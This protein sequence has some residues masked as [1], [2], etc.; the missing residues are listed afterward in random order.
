MKKIL[1]TVSALLSLMLCGCTDNEEI[2][3]LSETT[4]AV[5][6]Y[7]AHDTDMTVTGEV[8][9]IVGNEVTVALGTINER[10]GDSQDGKQG[11]RL[12]SGSPETYA[13]GETPQKLSDDKSS[14]IPLYDEMSHKPMD[15]EMPDFG[16]E[17]QGGGRHSASIEKNGK[18]ASYIIPVGMTID[19]LAGRSSDYSGITEGMVITLTIDESGTVRAVSVN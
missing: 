19:G 1:I 15:G 4:A 17:R 18:E 16:G 2:A 13:D 11:E 3:N 7:T 9:S 10:D 6:N 5:N 12:D 8:I 14:E